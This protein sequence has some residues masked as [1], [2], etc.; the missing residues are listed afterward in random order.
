MIC[1]LHGYLLE[2]SGSNLWTRAIVEALCRQGRT[3]HLMA[4]E[5][6]PE[7]Y[8]FISEA[9]RYHEDGEIETYYRAQTDFAGAG[10]CILHK[11]DIGEILPVY[12]RDR[13]DEFDRVV[14]MAEL[15][16]AEIERYVDLNVRAL[17]HVVRNNPIDVVH[18]NHAVLMSVVADRVSEAEGIP[19]TVMPHGSALEYALKRDPRLLRMAQRP[20]ARA[21]KVFVHGAEMRRRVEEI[22]PDI[23]GL[24]ER[25][26]DLHLGVDTSRFEPVSRAERP[27]RIARLRDALSGL[28]RGR[29][30]EQTRRLREGLEEASDISDLTELFEAA[31]EFDGK[32]PDAALEEKLGT[33]DW[34][35][36]PTLLY[37]GR[38]ISAKGIQDVVAA[39]PLL[40][41]QTPDLRL[42]IVGHGPLREPLEAMLW[43]LETGNREMFLAIV[44]E[45]R[46][47][48]GDPEGD[49]AG[50]PFLKVESFL[51]TLRTRGTLDDY[52][53]AGAR[54]IRPDRTIFTGYLTHRE[55]CHL[56]PCCDASIFPSLVKEAG[57]LVFLEALASGSFPLGTDFGGM[58]ASIDSV[59]AAGYPKLAEAMKLSPDPDR[60]ILDIVDRVPRALEM[61]DARRAELNRFAREHYDWSS[62]ARTL[63]AEAG[64]Q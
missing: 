11:P 19:F 54:H 55:L 34:R 17:T 25:M 30:P 60:T 45:G 15:G 13:Y 22:F 56:F 7:R 4:Q 63:A 10:C 12:V 26:V 59:A 5:N 35:S 46:R 23:D 14:P 16:D 1:I 64:I 20:F 44:A 6:H 48:E 3:V 18:A 40:L 47:L 50:G 36:D 24:S 8:P 53:Q 32:L 52:F 37:V 33:I 9:R 49:H 62:V 61:E 41:Q 21:S 27:E 31:G 29:T 42:L 28:E 38:L 58:G 51:E 2:G 39:L 57:P 43:A